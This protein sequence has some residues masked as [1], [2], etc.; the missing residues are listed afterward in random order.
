MAAAGQLPGTPACSGAMRAACRL[1]LGIGCRPC[2][3][4]PPAF[5]L[6]VFNSLLSSSFFPIVPPCGAEAELE[7]EAREELLR[8]FRAHG[9]KG[10]AGD[11][12]RVAAIGRAQSWAGG[13]ALLWR[14]PAAPTPGQT[15]LLA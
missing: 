15:L 9:R 2:L 13:C 8:R 4:I 10:G 7:E 11:E 1:P 12:V 3:L 5:A 6:L 14:R